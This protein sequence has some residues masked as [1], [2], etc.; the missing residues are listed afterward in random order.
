VVLASGCGRSGELQRPSATAV[1]AASPAGQAGR[2]PADPVETAARD[3]VADLAGKDFA[4]AVMGF[5]AAMHVAVPEERLAAV[6]GTAEVRLGPFVAVERVRVSRSG[7]YRVAFVRC[8]FEHGEVVVKV[9]YN[10]GLRVAGLFVLDP[11][12]DAPW[13]PPPYARLDAFDERDVRVGPAPLELPGLLSMPKGAG[14]FPAVVLVHGSGPQDADEKVGG[15]RVFK[16]IAS[17]LAS[18]GIAVLRY[19]KRSR[20]DPRGVAT[21]KE[22]SIDPARAAVDLLVRTP[23]VDPKRIILVGHSEG[24]YLAPRIASED[25]R[26]AAV[27]ILAGPT[28]PLQDLV[29][30]QV[31][32][33]ATLAPGAPAAQARIEEA[34]RFKAA[35]EDPTL[36]SDRTIPTLAGGSARGAYFLDLRGY[37]P[38]ILAATLACPI[39][40]VRGERDYQVGQADFDGWSKALGKQPLVTLK[41]YPA[42]NHLFVAGTGP[43]TP[44]EYEQPSNV[45]AAL[46]DDLARWIGH[47]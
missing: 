23:G 12:V 28:R 22:E 33:L 17:G 42:L 9:V 6:W 2:N 34:A 8:R 35:V 26:I 7:V 31:R 46:V 38:E 10:A 18:R 41:Q 3:L 36:T 37:H 14:P 40:I 15:V 47:L 45:D 5:D 25:A 21:V 11:P 30:E 20:I 13:T 19:V 32:Y 43:S 4:G 39:L 1:P 27:V 44:A 16:D 29:V 24:G